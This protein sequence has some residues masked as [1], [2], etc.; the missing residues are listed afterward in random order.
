MSVQ[1]SK[2]QVEQFPCL[3]D[4]YGTPDHL[5][6]TSCAGLTA[7]IDTPELK[8]YL[9]VLE[10]KGWKLDYILN[11]HH[12]FDH[13]GC[14]L[15]LKK[16]TGCKASEIVG[17]KGE[18]D[19][20]PGIDIAVDQGDTFDF[21][22][23]KI[24]VLNVGGHTHGHIAYFLPEENCAFVGD[25][26][27]ALGCGRLFEGTFPQMYDSLQRL[28]SLPDDTVLYC[29]HEYTMSNA[30]FALSVEPGNPMLQKRF[31]QIKKLREVGNPTVPSLLSEEKA[32]NPFLR[33][34][35]PEIRNSLKLSPDA[36]DVEVFA[37]IR[38][39]K[40]NF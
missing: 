26:L 33:T 8:P 23:K 28:A 36:K 27:F 10:R 2:L 9:H 34:S 16:S 37:A 25:S 18:K 35:S 17:P 6:M 32:T 14:N 31:E 20:I 13:A 3:N 21:G 12:H 4:N 11:T 38:K 15:E 19:K 40:D 39:A 29:A 22:A 5:L 1:A 7:A 30:K 24:H